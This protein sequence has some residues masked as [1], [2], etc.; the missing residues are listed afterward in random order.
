MISSGFP[1]PVSSSIFG[2]MFHLDYLAAQRYG[3]DDL[4][5][6][7][8]GRYP[9]SNCHDSV[10]FLPCHCSDAYSSLRIDRL[11][12]DLVEDSLTEYV[13]DADL[14]GLSYNFS[15]S[16]SG[17]YVQVQGYNDKLH[18]LLQ[19]VLERIKTIQVKRDRVEVMKEQVGLVFFFIVEVV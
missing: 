15:S 9:S 2:G 13:Y 16:S 19:H 1:R 14:A 3:T 11:Y 8:R 5:Q 7:I 4:L 12:S 6:S 18:V 17:M 10:S